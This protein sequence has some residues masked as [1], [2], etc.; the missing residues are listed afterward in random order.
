MLGE[1]SGKEWVLWVGLI[2]ALI[3][4]VGSGLI[5]SAGWLRKRLDRKARKRTELNHIVSVLERVVD[6]ANR[7]MNPPMEY[8]ALTPEASAARVEIMEAMRAFQKA[9]A[10]CPSRVSI[11]HCRRIAGNREW[12]TGPASQAFHEASERLTAYRQRVWDLND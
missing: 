4:I 8:A 7:G 5:P 1:L 9:V 2:A 12:G 11:P 3:T 10:E 6:A